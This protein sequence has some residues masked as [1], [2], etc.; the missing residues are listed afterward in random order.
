MMCKTVALAV[1]AAAACSAA[2]SQAK[3]PPAVA[4]AATAPGFDGATA[5]LNT[6]HPLK[7]E[8][9]RGHVVVVDFW[10]S[11][12]INCLQTLPT[13]AKLEHD[14]A[15]QPFVVVG[16]QSPKFDA[17]TEQGRLRAVLAENHISHPIAI[18]ASMK[19]WNAWGVQGWPSIYVLDAHGR[20]VWEGSGEPDPDALERIVLA[21]IA[22]GDQEHALDNRP[23]AGL[24]PEHHT[25][26]PLAAPGK[27]LAL[28]D[29]GL[30]ISDSAHHRVV[31]TD[32]SG[33]VASV[34]GSGLAG[35]LD[36]DFA[37]ASFRKPQGLA[38]AG[39][40]V[41]VADT[42][43]HELRVID[44][45]AHTVATV[46]GTGTLGA[47]P[48]EADPSP[49]RQTALRSPWDVA[50]AG[51]TVYI[52]LAGAH[53]IAAYDPKAGTIRAFAG[54]GRE[55]RRDGRGLDASFAQPSGLATDGTTLY[56]ADS[57][58]SSIRAVTL[59]TAE[60]RTLVGEDLFVFG[61]VDG[62]GDTVR[63]QH[64]IGIAWGNGALWIADTYN[65]KLKRLD[66]K[67]RTVKT[68]AG[69][70]LEP[71]GVTVRG[72]DVIVADTHHD[73]IVDGKGRAITLAGLAAPT[74]G[75]A[76]AAPQDQDLAT[77]EPL[78]L[79]VVALAP[80]AGT[81]HVHW[82]VPDGTAINEDAPFKVRWAHVA[83]LAS[84][85]ATV[86]T[87]GKTVS[88]GFDLPLSIGAGA[89]S[90]TARLDVVLCDEK[91]HRICMPIRRR[92]VLAVRPGA[93]HDARVSATLPPA[94]L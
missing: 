72:D 88:S 37:S 40:L 66:P 74:P 20:V 13:L 27:I 23:I 49:A 90:L 19:I 3:P 63:L 32:A 58:T 79:G 55:A 89:A 36:G 62:T 59:A 9:L 10:T 38:E 82:D 15:G 69:G 50:I 5:W 71:A 57:E 29:G 41:Y 70:F 2:T 24:R 91:T 1:I 92:L 34:V 85:P 86:A 7:L 26:G 83:G 39:D 76:V 30:A 43:N 47:A 78:D 46:A 60:V 28:A 4:I 33:K 67:T 64:P 84:A 51:G 94:R 12:C 75:I 80:G 21:T 45:R 56:V 25:D 53:Q 44:R 42:E 61:D 18:D 93:A 81:V 16:V 35:A 65:S 48:L 73:R 54:N 77:F 11:C 14:L 87:T 6:D 17:E 68:V 31:F 8:E 52:A 22:H